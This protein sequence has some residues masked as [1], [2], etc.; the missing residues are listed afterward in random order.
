[1]KEI[2][3]QRDGAS[4]YQLVIYFTWRNFIEVIPK[5]QLWWY[6]KQQPASKFSIWPTIHD[7]SIQDSSSFSQEFSILWGVS[8]EYSTVNSSVICTTHN[9][10]KRLLT[11]IDHV[12]WTIQFGL[13]IVCL[14]SIKISD[15]V[16]WLPYLRTYYMPHNITRTIV[17]LDWTFGWQLMSRLWS[18]HILQFDG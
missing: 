7:S 10:P 13:D 16:Q 4:T 8:W 15:I 2:S 5:I 12:H 17:C 3:V 1:M 18:L 14:N 9:L 11:T 6:V